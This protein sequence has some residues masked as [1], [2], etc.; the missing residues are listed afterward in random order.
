MKMKRLLMYL[1]V[2][3]ALLSCGKEEEGGGTT[4]DTQPAKLSV[5]ANV[6]LHS[7]TETSLTFQWSAVDGAVSYGWKLSQ[8]GSEVK[9]GTANT[10][11]VKIDGLT[12]GSTY[13]F[14]VCAKGS[15]SSSEYSTPIEASTEG[16]AP[17]PSATVICVDAPLVLTLDSAPVLGTS[18]LIQV[19][20]SNGTLVDKIDLSDI[21]TV[22]VLES[23][24]MVPKEQMTNETKMTTFMDAIYGGGR[25]RIVNYTPLRINGRNLEI[26]LHYGVLDFSTSYYVTMDAG[27]VKGHSGV[28]AGE[29]AFTTAA[30][31]SSDTSL[32]VAADGSGDFCTLQRALGF[33]NS[34]GAEITLAAGTY[35]ECLYLRDKSGI[36]LKGSSRDKVRIEY[37]NN[38]SY[39]NGSGGGVSSKPSVGS[40][41]GTNGGRSLFL[42]ENCDNL[43]L[44]NLSIENTFYAS[45]HKGQAECI[46][47]NSG[48]NTHK[49]TIENCSLV[50]WQ[51]TFL[52][53]GSVW[54]H[55]SLI[56]G[57]C[58]YVWGYP[59][60]CLFEDCEIRSR[61]AGYIVQARVPSASQV[62][63]VFLNCTLTAEDGVADGSVYLARSA[64]QE[65]SFDNVVFVNCKM[66]S[67]ISS[68]G[69]YTKPEPNPKTPT[70][71]SGWREYGSVTP[72]GK[73]I[74]GHNSY[75]YVMTEAE[76]KKYSSKSEVLGW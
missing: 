22:D 29:W 60:A 16:S 58:D 18:G 4:P 63:F 21:S 64:G 33:A 42:V 66:A 26:K 48:N 40:S 6:K 25:Y 13:S 3:L 73:A 23:G 30:A 27:V 69:W 24:V 72:A 59:A 14:S 10:R 56:A 74:T 41:V 68:G 47:F 17:D 2:P 65:G 53:K 7:A 36:T 38:E 44:E 76:A 54:V 37:P 31:P 43:V 34:K 71:T 19:Y 9:S 57:H 70:A 67:A 62:G 5:P 20:K 15:S 55:N 28:K 51:D 39:A 35:E 45:D 49:L 1:L 32:K 61:A 46:Y 75:G 11:N 8:S 12:A 50:S 52:C